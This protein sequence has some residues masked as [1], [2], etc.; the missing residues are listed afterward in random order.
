[1]FVPLLLH[2]MASE[3]AGIIKELLVLEFDCDNESD[4]GEDLVLCDSSSDND[5]DGD[6]GG[7]SAELLTQLRGSGMTIP[8][9]R[10]P[11]FVLH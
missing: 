9:T 8:H 3:N 10:Y 2:Y 4:S 5:S 1:M 11:N 6:E 7:H